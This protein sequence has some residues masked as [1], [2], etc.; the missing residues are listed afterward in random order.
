MEKKPWEI[1][2]DTGATQET[3]QETTQE[4][5]PWQTQYE[6][7]ARSKVTSGA[8]LPETSL[9]PSPVPGAATH[10]NMTGNGQQ[11][12]KKGL[13]KSLESDAYE[14]GRKIKQDQ[15]NMGTYAQDFG[16]GAGSGAMMGWN[17]E[18]YGHLLALVA[19]GSELLGGQEV[20]YNEAYEFGRDAI[21]RNLEESKER[22]PYITG[23]GEVAG[24][25]GSAL[26]PGG[27]AAKGAGLLGK[28]GAAAARPVGLG[29]TMA[30]GAGTGAAYGGGTS[31]ASPL[32]TSSE[33]GQFLQ[34]VGLGAAVGAAVPAGLKATGIGTQAAGLATRAPTVVS[35]VMGNLTN[36][37]TQAVPIAGGIMK[38]VEKGLKDAGE[39]SWWAQ[40]LAD[41]YSDVG[42]PGGLATGIGTTGAV[43]PLTSMISG[44]VGRG[45]QTIGKYISNP[46]KMLEQVAGSKFERGA[47]LAAARGK[48]ALNAFI[49]TQMNNPEFR[50]LMGVDLSKLN[51][52]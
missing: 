17:D 24:M 13:A 39:K 1:E 38:S 51:E 28:A 49:Y 6:A 14:L 31:E 18:A 35:K 22:S 33:R 21:R 5:A 52:E 10:E 37:A 40:R 8:D 2:Y 27:L 9:I 29:S 43:L 32:E 4:S 36:K 46:H 25:V 50:E 34:D 42:G 44:A 45:G 19:K 20:D 15:E 41:A 16:R 3:T 30:R 26:I 11:K 12:V 7:P 23:G 47:Q 48:E